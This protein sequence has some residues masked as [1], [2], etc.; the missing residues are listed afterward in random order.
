VPFYVVAVLP[1]TIPLSCRTFINV[2]RTAAILAAVLSVPAKLKDCVHAVTLNSSA[3][4]TS[5][6]CPVNLVIVT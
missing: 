1:L 2:A 5:P 3:A 6:L 4:P